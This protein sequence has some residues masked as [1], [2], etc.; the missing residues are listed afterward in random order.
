MDLLF[1]S[2]QFQKTDLIF[3]MKIVCE[4][5]RNLRETLKRLWLSVWLSIFC[6]QQAKHW[7]ISLGSHP[8]EI[9]TRLVSRGRGACSVPVSH[10]TGVVCVLSP[11]VWPFYYML[12][13]AARGAATSWGLLVSPAPQSQPRLLASQ[14]L[15]HIMMKIDLDKKSL[16]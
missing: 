11:A 5:R 14:L 7:N 12:C 3:H 9:P 8:E 13:H 15:N 16:I 10:R 2:S 6:A 1:E 4:N